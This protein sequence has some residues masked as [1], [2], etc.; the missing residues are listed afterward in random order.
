MWND[1]LI[2][3]SYV[4]ISILNPNWSLLFLNST[5]IHLLFYDP[6]NWQSIL[7]LN[8]CTVWRYA[9][10]VTRDHQ[11]DFPNRSSEKL[12]YTEIFAKTECL[13]RIPFWRFSG[14]QSGGVSPRAVL[15]RLGPYLGLLLSGVT[16]RHSIVL[17]THSKLRIAV[18]NNIICQ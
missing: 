4:F 11:N 9:C 17:I 7:M 16:L 3:S 2:V 8:S 5:V 14:E 10:H 1:V 18:E 13:R 12:K 6:N 15:I